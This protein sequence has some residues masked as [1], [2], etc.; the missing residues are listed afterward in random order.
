MSSEITNPLAAIL[1]AASKTTASKSS[2]AK[3]HQRSRQNQESIFDIQLLDTSGSMSYLLEDGSRKI[4]TLS[5]IFNQLPYCP[6]NYSFD[7]KTEAINYSTKLTASGGTNLALALQTI[8][9]L[10]PD[11]ILIV[12]DGVP[13]SVP[14][15]FEAAARLQSQISCFYVGLDSD[16]DAKNFLR[17]LATDYG[18]KYEDCDISQ[19]SQRKQ[20]S[21][22]IQNLL[23]GG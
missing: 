19:L 13:D 5:T 11:R 23:P 6:Q 16:L 9:T 10:N 18:G 2:Q 1:A 15:A 12:S 22:R 17:K 20:L 3:V 14:D 4:D 21:Q 8:D 7:S